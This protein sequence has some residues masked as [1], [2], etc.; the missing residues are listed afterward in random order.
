MHFSRALP[1]DPRLDGAVAFTIHRAHSFALSTQQRRV[2]EGRVR[3]R[4]QDSAIA[5]THPNCFDPSVCM[6]LLREIYAT[7]EKLVV[8]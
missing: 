2:G 5:W 4:Q 7:P 6:N 3:H 8:E 1:G